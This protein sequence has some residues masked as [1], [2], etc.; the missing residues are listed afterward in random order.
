MQP[1]GLARGFS[2]SLLRWIGVAVIVGLTACQPSDPLEVRVSAATP[3]AFAMWQSRQFSEGRAPLRKDFDFACQEIRLKIMADR[4]ASGSEPVDRA[5]RE[6]IDGRPVREV[7]QLGWESRLWRLYPEYAELERVI[8]VNAA[9]ETRPGDTLSARHLRD[10]H[11]AHVTRLERVRGEIAA[12]ERALAPLVQKTGRRFIPP[13]K[14][15]DD[16]AARR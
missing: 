16:G 5:L 7:L 9:L 11:V 12:A 4:E 6:K 14:T 1:H 15:G 8:A 2:A 10:T 3:V 13:R